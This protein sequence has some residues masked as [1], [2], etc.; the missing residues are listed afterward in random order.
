M[1]AQRLKSI[2]ELATT[3]DI[4]LLTYSSRHFGGLQA[5]L[6]WK[7]ED[8]CKIHQIVY[9]QTRKMHDQIN[10]V[11]LE[12]HGDDESSAISMSR[13][14]TE[15]QTMS[16]AM[17]RLTSL[18]EQ[19]T[20][21]GLWAMSEQFLGKICT[22]LQQSLA[23]EAKLFKASWRWKDIIKAFQAADVNLKS[24]PYYDLVD[25]CRVLNNNIKHQPNVGDELAAFNTFMQSKGK[26]IDSLSIDVQR[27]YAG[28]ANF[29]GELLQMCDGVVE[30]R[31]CSI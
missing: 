15:I 27:Y 29:F 28:S 24:S 21:V 3:E 18:S 12:A 19:L 16:D 2:M 25:E 14:W 26:N 17:H 8:F 7:L 10:S 31:K 22:H 30:A 23:I 5:K 1:N 9:L 4:L 20:I 11:D 13:R 6:V